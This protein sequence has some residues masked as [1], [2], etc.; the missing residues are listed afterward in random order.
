MKKKVVIVL[1]NDECT[2]QYVLGSVFHTHILSMTL[3]SFLTLL[4]LSFRSSFTLL[5]LS[6]FCL[7][8]LFFRSPYTLLSLSLRSL[9]T[10]LSG[11]KSNF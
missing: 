7:F 3:H 4:P 9:F 2:G 11:F 8:S 6:L 1:D 10:L 5:S